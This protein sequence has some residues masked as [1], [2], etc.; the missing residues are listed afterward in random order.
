MDEIEHQ[1]PAPGRA[2]HARLPA[3]QLSV[4][5][6]FNVPGTRVRHAGALRLHLRRLGAAD[7]ADGAAWSS[8]SASGE[9]AT[10]MLQGW[11]HR[12]RVVR[13]PRAAVRH[14]LLRRQARRRRA[15][16]SSPTRTSTA[17][18][19]AVYAPRGRSTAA[20][21]ARRATASASC[22]STSARR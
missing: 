2:V 22:R 7:R 18:S 6:L 4:L 11:R 8:R 15:A 17:L 12:P 13:L 16:R 19:L 21:G 20:S 10:A 3:V 14:R 9:R 1:G 5:A